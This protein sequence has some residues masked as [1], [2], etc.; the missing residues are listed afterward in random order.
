MGPK[1]VG[2]KGAQLV[3]QNPLGAGGVGFHRPKGRPTGFPKKFPLKG[4]RSFSMETTSKLAKR[5]VQLGSSCRVSGAISL[6]RVRVSMET[7]KKPVS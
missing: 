2:W 3:Q 7:T 6:Q 5:G 4:A 1:L